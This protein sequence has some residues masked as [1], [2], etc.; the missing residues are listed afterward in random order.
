MTR[1]FPI[2]SLEDFETK[3]KKRQNLLE[4]SQKTTVEYV[5]KNYVEADLNNINY[6]GYNE[7]EI[8]EVK[9]FY[10]DKHYTH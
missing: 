2:I 4:L 3:S 9:R 10:N 8:T 6:Y 1:K 5:A 7:D